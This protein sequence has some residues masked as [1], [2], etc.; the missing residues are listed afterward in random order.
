MFLFDSLNQSLFVTDLSGMARWSVESRSLH[1]SNPTV[2]CPGKQLVTGR[3]SARR[4]NRR[5]WQHRNRRLF[6]RRHGIKTSRCSMQGQP[7]LSDFN[8]NDRST[9]HNVTM[10]S[11]IYRGSRQRQTILT[12]LSQQHSYR[13]TVHGWPKHSSQ[14]RSA[15]FLRARCRCFDLYGFELII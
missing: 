14:P 7:T 6:I 8:N 1:H 15:Q 13:I 11:R 2:H 5:R 3:A 9:G 12:G 4:Y 10:V